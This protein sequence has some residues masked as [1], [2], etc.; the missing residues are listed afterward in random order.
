MTRISVLVFFVSALPWAAMVQCGSN[1]TIHNLICSCNGIVFG[2]SICNGSGTACQDGTI[3]CGTDEV[4]NPC[5]VSHADNCSEAR[6]HGSNDSVQASNDA[7]ILRQTTSIQQLAS[8]VPVCG[9]NGS[10]R[11]F[12]LSLEPRRLELR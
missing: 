6:L 7:V 12:D 4:G 5:N 1:V 10:V 3:S 11:T 9:G 8:L 2:E